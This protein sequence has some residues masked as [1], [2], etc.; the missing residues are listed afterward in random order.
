MNII[1]LSGG[2]GKRLWPLSSD[3]RSKQFLKVLR[4]PEGVPESMIQRIYRQLHELKMDTQIVI[5]TTDAQ[6][7]TILRQLGSS[8]DIA[9]EPERRDTFPAIALA[10]TFLA[11]ERHCG[12]EETV[13]VMPVDAYT[14]EGYFQTILKMDRA[15][16]ARAADMVLMGV[17]PTYPA[18]KYGYI[19]PVPERTSSV[20]KVSH[21]EEKPATEKA[22]ELLDMGAFWNGGVFAFKMG[23]MMDIVRRY[24]EPESYAHLR[25]NYGLLRKTSF[26]YE[27]VE[28][29]QSI[30][31][32]PYYGMWKDLGTWNTLSDV[33]K[34]P[35]SG[36]VISGEGT[37]NTHIINELDIPV[38]ALGLKDAVVAASPDGILITD[39]YASSFLKP[40]VDQIHQRPMYEERQWG[41][42][43]VLNYMTHENGKRSLT[44]HL[45]ILPG[46]SLSYQCHKNRDE[47]WTVVDGMGDLLLDGHIRNIRCG[48]V[49]YISSGMKHALRAATPIHLIEVQIGRELTEED[50]ERFDWSWDA[51]EGTIEP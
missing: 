27:I 14:E 50:I 32:V 20:M 37:E 23:Y 28:A 10:A 39:K 19:V 49:A 25:E 17:R 18:T 12:M 22:R 13:V 36:I 45:N 47:I 9:L 16:Q 4:T 41:S 6:K 7:D 44:K 48:D 46:K 3:T 5:S 43:K 30:A 33:M 42:Y 8:V 51:E 21:F 24:I 29:C 38:V 34:E 11:T 40:Y 1:L 15:V 31:M 26:D 35:N 2:S